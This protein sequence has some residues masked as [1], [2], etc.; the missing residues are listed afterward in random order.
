M[1]T[2]TD[3]QNEGRAGRPARQSP[4]RKFNGSPLTGVD[5]TNER[6]QTPPEIFGFP[7]PYSTGARGSA[8]SHT[9]GSTDVTIMDG[10]LEESVTG[11]SG[12]PITS[13]GAPGS[14]GASNSS[15][16]ETVTYTDPFGLQGGVN[17]TV[18]VSG[19]ISGEG[20][21]TQANDMGY[22]GGPTLPSLQN[23]RPVST[24]AG[25]GRVSTHRSGRG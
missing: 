5:P 12:S 25:A 18:T 6:G 13:T 1:A 9:D 17:R 11:L 15:G 3:G 8:G 20:D 24:G 2:A 4:G 23:A 22:A 7:I 14:Q 21:W 10:Q 19:R 16:G